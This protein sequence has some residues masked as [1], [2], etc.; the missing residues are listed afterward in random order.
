MNGSWI[1]N[2]YAK[3]KEKQD[4]D[5]EIMIKRSNR[6]K[7]S[8]SSERSW[9]KIIIGWLCYYKCQETLDHKREI[10]REV[11]RLVKEEDICFEFCNVILFRLRK[12]LLNMNTT[13]MLTFAAVFLVLIENIC[14]LISFKQTLIYF[15]NSHFPSYI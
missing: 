3:I 10:W 2:M 5:N 9:P 6:V 14:Y 8:Q 12:A 1:L 4:A 7:K 13:L 11:E 15:E